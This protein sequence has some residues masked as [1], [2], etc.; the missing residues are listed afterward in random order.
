MVEKSLFFE[1]F[2]SFRYEIMP[3]LWSGWLFLC[4]SKQKLRIDNLSLI[5]YLKLLRDKCGTS[6][7][8]VEGVF[9]HL[10]NFFR[11]HC[12]SFIAFCTSFDLSGI[13][14]ISRRANM[15]V[16]ILIIRGITFNKFRVS[17]L[18]TYVIKNAD[19]QNK[20]R[21]YKSVW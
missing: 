15:S 4:V 3:S 8:A 9:G 1:S 20:F 16:Q 19:L 14:Q 6:I 12:S 11:K 18:T 21:Q 2:F 7:V 13:N 5:F 17:F 10:K